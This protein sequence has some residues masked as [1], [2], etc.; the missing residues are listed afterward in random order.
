MA[1]IGV[2][3]TVARPRV[4][5]VREAACQRRNDGFVPKPMQ[6]IQP[7]TNLNVPSLAS[8]VE[9]M[10]SPLEARNQVTATAR[11]T[12]CRITVYPTSEGAVLLKRH[13]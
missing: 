7:T 11:V 6:A 2:L 8:T 9:A 13:V 3:A 5:R 1:V 12:S 4:G 10:A